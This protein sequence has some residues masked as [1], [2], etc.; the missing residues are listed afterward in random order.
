[1]NQYLYFER[2]DEGDIREQ[3]CEQ[4][5]WRVVFWGPCLRWTY[6]QFATRGIRHD[7]SIIW[8]MKTS[9]DIP[10]YEPLVECKMDGKS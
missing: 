5:C 3:I 1:M 4:L 6:E 9:G 2:G 10:L 8:N 7:L